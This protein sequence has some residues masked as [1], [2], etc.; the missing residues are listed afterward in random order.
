MRLIQS[1]LRSPGPIVFA[2][3]GPGPRPEQR[4]AQIPILWPRYVNGRVQV[5]PIHPDQIPKGWQS[6]QV[7]VPMRLATCEETDCPTLATGWTRVTMGDGNVDH[8]PGHISRDQAAA[9]YGYHGAASN[10]PA[11][12]HM[13]AGQSCPTLHKLPS[14]VPPLYTVNGKPTLWNEFEDALGGGVHHIQQ[15][16]KEG[17]Y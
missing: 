17:R 7:H 12:E 1:Q 6:V 5:M 3:S 15:I 10:P 16:Q 2:P 13:S 11:V 9:I 8:Q 4:A 14:G